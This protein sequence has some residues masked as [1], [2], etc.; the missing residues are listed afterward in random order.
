MLRGPI[1][2]AIGARG[3]DFNGTDFMLARFDAG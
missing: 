1:F 3:S 2:L